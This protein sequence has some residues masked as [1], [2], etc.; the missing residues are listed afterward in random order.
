MTVTAVGN[1][2]EWRHHQTEGVTSVRVEHLLSR[3]GGAGGKNIFRNYLE[4]LVKTEHGIG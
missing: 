3:V 2:V 1:C 4:M